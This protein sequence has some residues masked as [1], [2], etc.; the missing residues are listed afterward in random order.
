MVVYY[1]GR[2]S[3]V[4]KINPADANG[5]DGIIEGLCV[6][7][8]TCGFI[9]CDGE[10]RS[11]TASE[12]VSWAVIDNASADTC[13]AVFHFLAEGE[14]HFVK[15][16]CNVDYWNSPVTKTVYDS[17]KLVIFVLNARCCNLYAVP[18][19]FFCIRSEDDCSHKEKFCEN[20]VY[21]TSVLLTKG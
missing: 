10:C 21:R 2:L 18:V 15:V 3:C 11:C 7:L 9:H 5:G 19:A 1:S 17:F 20:C 14:G 4:R 12:A 8:I 16:P 13:S 6:N